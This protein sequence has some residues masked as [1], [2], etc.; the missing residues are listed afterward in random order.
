MNNMGLGK[1]AASFGLVFLIAVAGLGCTK[2]L[3]SETQATAVTG[4]ES[5]DPLSFAVLDA[6][7][8]E[9]TFDLNEFM[10]TNSSEVKQTMSH[11]ETPGGVPATCTY[12]LSQDGKYEVLQMEKDLG[13]GTQVDEYFNLTDA[14]F[15]TRSTMYNDGKVDPVDKY[16]ITEGVL[17]KIDGTAKTVT[18]I[19]DLN[20]PSSEEIGANI[21]IYLSFDEIRT[22]YA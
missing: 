19:T 9:Y 4:Q 7:T 11:G 20:D 5:V 1:K 15:I 12:T 8:R 17:Y 2:K 22:E 3:E 18:K 6:K 13:G 21:D 10:R 14:V 16:Y